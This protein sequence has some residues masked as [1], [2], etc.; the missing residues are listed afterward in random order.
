MRAGYPGS[1]IEKVGD[2]EGGQGGRERWRFLWL[3]NDGYFCTGT[4]YFRD[5]DLGIKVCRSY[6]P[7]QIYEGRGPW[8]SLSVCHCRQG[9][10][11]IRG[12]TVGKMV[13]AT[14]I[15]YWCG[16]GR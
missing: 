3:R 13:S 15:K 8:E 4:G 14:T 6:L 12:R 11:K 9:E 16:A 2:I 1:V 7:F 5:A 10:S